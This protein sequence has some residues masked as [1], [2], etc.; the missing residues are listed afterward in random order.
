M[1]WRLMLAYTA[2]LILAKFVFQISLFC[3]CQCSSYFFEPYC[4]NNP[5]CVSCAGS[6]MYVR[7]LFCFL[8]RLRCL[9][10]GSSNI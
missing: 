5:I 10:V 4:A 3:L 8:L 7:S 9:C 2:L 6:N 1:F